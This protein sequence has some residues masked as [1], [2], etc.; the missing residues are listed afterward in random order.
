MKTKRLF[1]KLFLAVC[2]LMAVPAMR[3]EAAQSMDISTGDILVD[4]NKIQ[5]GNLPTNEELRQDDS[6]IE[7]LTNNAYTISG[8]AGSPRKIIIKNL[9]S[10]N[11]NALYLNFNNLSALSELQLIIDNANVY[12]TVQGINNSLKSSGG[13]AVEIKDKG[14][15]HLSGSNSC[16]TITGGSN[17]A[18]STTT[19]AVNTASGSSFIVDSGRVVLIAG[20]GSNTSNVPFNGGLLTIN[21][22]TLEC[23]KNGNYTKYGTGTFNRMGG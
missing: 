5:Q 20:G 18:G 6:S 1:L 14:Q 16:I 21:D 11:R 15:L 8:T 4:R 17:S 23:L 7:S 2:F 22:G 12:I 13:N 3:A 9:N 19:A 10:T